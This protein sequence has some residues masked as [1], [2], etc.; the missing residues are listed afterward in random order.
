MEN[1]FICFVAAAEAD[2]QSDRVYIY[3]LGAGF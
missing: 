2:F 3:S 1:L